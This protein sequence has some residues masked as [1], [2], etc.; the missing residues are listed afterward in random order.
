M[1]MT[2]GGGGELTRQEF[3]GDLQILKEILEKF[4]CLSQNC[5]LDTFVPELSPD[6]ESAH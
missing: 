6:K 2:G 3:L 4:S 1:G 5:N